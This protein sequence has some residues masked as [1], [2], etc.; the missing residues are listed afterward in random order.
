[1]RAAVSLGRARD[2]QRE[3]GRAGIDPVPTPRVDR[4]KPGSKH[5]VI[6][7]GGIPLAATLT[8]GNRHDVTQ[9]RRGGSAG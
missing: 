9:P 1:M 6:D 7:V 3:G 8:G 4:R 5:H 2:G